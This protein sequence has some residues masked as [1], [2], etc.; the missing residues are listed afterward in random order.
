MTH[1]KYFNNMWPHTVH[2]VYINCGVYTYYNMS[3]FMYVYMY[4]MYVVHMYVCV[5]NTYMHTCY[6][7]LLKNTNLLNTKLHWVLVEAVVAAPSP[8]V[9]ASLVRT[10]S[11]TTLLLLSILVFV[12]FSIWTM[13]FYRN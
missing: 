2:H 7:T 4:Y 12:F 5:L 11:T 3:S 6:P 8:I 1:I 9:P 13:D 10:T